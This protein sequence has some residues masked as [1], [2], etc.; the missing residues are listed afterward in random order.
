MSVKNVFMALAELKEDTIAIK[1]TVLTKD[2]EILHF[3]QATP[4]NELPEEVVQK[5]THAM[6][7][8]LTKELKP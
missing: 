5:V 6:I 4:P 7:E 1:A 8:V 2:G 3:L